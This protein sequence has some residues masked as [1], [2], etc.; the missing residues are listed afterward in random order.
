MD[1][2]FQI[3]L[4]LS[5]TLSQSIDVDYNL[6]AITDFKRGLRPDPTKLPRS[7]NSLLCKINVCKPAKVRRSVA[8]L[9]RGF[10]NTAML[11]VPSENYTQGLKRY[12]HVCIKNFLQLQYLSYIYIYEYKEIQ[13]SWLITVFSGLA[14]EKKLSNSKFPLIPIVCTVYCISYTV[15]GYK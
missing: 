5:Y 8:R 7:G 11:G 14:I 12:E 6:N 4:L 15:C 9:V 10:Q 1:D 2:T 3:F 13:S